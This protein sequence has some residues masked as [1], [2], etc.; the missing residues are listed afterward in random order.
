[1]NPVVPLHQ[2]TLRRQHARPSGIDLGLRRR[3]RQTQVVTPRHEACA[4]PNR[5]PQG[6]I[7]HAQRA[8]IHLECLC[9][10]HHGDVV[11]QLH[12][13]AVGLREP[14]N[15]PEVFFGVAIDLQRRQ[16]RDVKV[17]RREAEG[18][19][20]IAFDDHRDVAASQFIL[21]APQAARAVVVRGDRER[22]GS[23]QPIVVEH[24]VRGGLRRHVR[25][26]ALIH[27]AVH[28]HEAFC[29]GRHELPQSRSAN[30]G[31]R[32]EIER[33][34]DMRERRNLG[35]HAVLGQGA[36]YLLFPNRGSHQ[37]V[38]KAVGLPQLKTNS[39]DGFAEV[40]GTR[41]L[42]EGVQYAQLVSRQIVGFARGKSP[43]QGGIALLGLGDTPFTLRR[44]GSRVE[45]QRLV[46][47]AKIP[48]IMQQP[49]VG[50]DLG[51]HANPEAHVLLELRRVGERIRRVRCSRLELEQRPEKQAERR[52]LE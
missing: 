39:I 5:R 29:S 25:V 21:G 26:Q 44:G 33:G 27:E 10:D 23:E 11:R 51:V 38:A 9:Q 15:R 34:L 13:R 50:G 20:L 49:L 4:A 16:E 19:S 35:R 2:V 47:Q 42:A 52:E 24:Q 22:P 7:Q 1:V 28:P 6:R 12:G 30:L 32:F 40:R 18:A 14:C 41:P 46:Y 3:A 45:A 36:A 48:I 17:A 8:H 31:I 37:A 43:Q